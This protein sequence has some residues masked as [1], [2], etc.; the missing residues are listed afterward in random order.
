MAVHSSPTANPPTPN[1]SGN[2]ACAA[3]TTPPTAPG[4]PPSPKHSRTSQRERY[5]LSTQTRAVGRSCTLDDGRM[6]YEVSLADV[7]SRPTAVVAVTT[8]WQEFPTLWGQLLG[9][10]WDCLHA[11]GIHRGC[12]NI[13]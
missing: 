10:V 8:T 11:G 5:Q 6:D 1:A 12:R 9:Q 4:I 3:R 13:M 2:S 7:E